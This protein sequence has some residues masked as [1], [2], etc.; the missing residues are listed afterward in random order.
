MEETVNQQKRAICYLAYPIA[1]T[2][3]SVAL[4]CEL[5]GLGILVLGVS[6]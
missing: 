1:M 3:G 4:L 6:K 5:C 2:L